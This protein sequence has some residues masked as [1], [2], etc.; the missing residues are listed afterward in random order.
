MVGSRWALVIMAIPAL[1]VLIGVPAISGSTRTVLGIPMVF[2][3][4]FAWLPLTTLCLWI[5]WHFFERKEYQ[6]LEDQ[7]E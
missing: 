5:S 1:A 7:G 4:L 2:V 6:K 3:W